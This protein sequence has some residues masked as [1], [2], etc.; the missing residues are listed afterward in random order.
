MSP[1]W[2]AS[3]NTPYYKACQCIHDNRDQKE[4]QPNFNQSRE[5]DVASGLAEFVGNNAGHGV[6]RGEQGARNLRAIADDHGHGHGLAESAAE[7]EDNSAHDSGACV[8]Q[9]ADADH[10]PAR[11]AQSKYAF[12]LVLRN[13]RQDFT[14][15]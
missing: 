10:L 12:P 11:R 1:R 9:D 2:L 3:R 8:P 6:S 4:S 15:D 13:G 5:V 14:S 7:A